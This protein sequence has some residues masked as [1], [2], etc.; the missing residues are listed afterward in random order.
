MLYQ[1]HWRGIGRQV[2]RCGST[3][4]NCGPGTYKIMCVADTDPIAPAFARSHSLHPP[5]SPERGSKRGAS[6]PCP[7]PTTP[8]T[9]AY[10]ATSNICD[11]APTTGIVGD[12]LEYPS[13]DDPRLLVRC[14]IGSLSLFDPLVLRLVGSRF[15]GNI[16]G[17]RTPNAGPLYDA[18]KSTCTQYRL[19]LPKNMLT[20]RNSHERREYLL[21]TN[22][23][24]HHKSLTKSI[25]G[26]W[27][28]GIETRGFAM[29]LNPMPSS[30]RIEN[31]GQKTQESPCH[32]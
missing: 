16:L 14:R 8:I 21:L 32:L 25:Q 24:I 4:P 13:E 18:L 19:Q 28:C 11:P 31:I 22:K 1:Y 6:L 12:V 5:P 7:S 30:K 26:H 23:S 10:D 29:V 3:F 27:Y 20:H 9:F 2:V 15:G 17:N